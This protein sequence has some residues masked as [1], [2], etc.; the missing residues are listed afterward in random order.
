L[1]LNAIGLILTRISPGKMGYGSLEYIPAWLVCHRLYNYICL[2]T[3][4]GMVSMYFTFFG[5]G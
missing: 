2:G 5:M 1:K 3:V 4:Y